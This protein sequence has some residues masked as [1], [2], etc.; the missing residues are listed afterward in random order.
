M[1]TLGIIP[2]EN[3][4]IESCGYLNEGNKKWDDDKDDKDDTSTKMNSIESQEMSQGESNFSS[5]PY[6]AQSQISD[7]FTL[8]H[9]RKGA[10]V[11]KCFSLFRNYLL[12]K[13][14]CLN[15]ASWR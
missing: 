12:R 1:R 14:P 3:T 9:L 2:E 11:D 13:Y 15:P 10:N 4:I 7:S 8:F 6:L 5:F